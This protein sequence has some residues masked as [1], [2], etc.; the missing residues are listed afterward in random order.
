MYCLQA[1]N[2]LRILA[3]GFVLLISLAFIGCQSQPQIEAF[4]TVP[5]GGEVPVGGE[6]PIEVRIEPIDSP[7]TFKWILDKGTGEMRLSSSQ[8]NKGVY[9]APRRAGTYW[10]SVQMF[11]WGKKA[12]EKAIPIKVVEVGAVAQNP[13][14]AAPTPTQPAEPPSPTQPKTFKPLDVAAYFVPSG[15]MGDGEKGEKY[16]T[17]DIASR[18]SPHSLPLC[19]KFTYKIGPTGW[20]AVAYQNRDKNWGKFPGR[21]LRGVKKLAFKARGL[22]GQEVVEF[23][24][25]GMMDTKPYRDSFE[26]S[27]GP[28]ALETTW[29]QYEIALT[30]EDLSSVISG[31]IWAASRSGNPPEITFFLDDIR[32]E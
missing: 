29:K 13:S 14:G 7:V 15:W 18:E 11:Y 32:Y 22:T 1:R 10:V 27:T 20:A 23:K 3:A 25:G 8:S 31:F 4:Q 2:M 28:V 30:G 17:V 9:I 5:P 12:D 21:D 6:I 19:I 16:I 26:V 24:A